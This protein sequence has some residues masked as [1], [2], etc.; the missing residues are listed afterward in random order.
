MAGPALPPTCT[1]PTDPVGTGVN[2]NLDTF[3]DGHSHVSG[4]A[5]LSVRSLSHRSGLHAQISTVGRLYYMLAHT[6]PACFF[7]FFL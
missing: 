6:I 2:L 3:L 7:W 1:H 5:C 4:P